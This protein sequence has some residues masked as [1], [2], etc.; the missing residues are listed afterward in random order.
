MANI[1][2]TESNPSWHMN[3]SNSIANTCLSPTSSEM[4]RFSASN[5]DLTLHPLVVSSPSASLL[6]STIVLG[7]NAAVTTPSSRLANPT[8]HGKKSLFLIST[9]LAA[10]PKI[11]APTPA[12]L[13]RKNILVLSSALT[14]SAMMTCKSVTTTVKPPPTQLNTKCS[15]I[16]LIGNVDGNQ[17]TRNGHASSSKTPNTATARMKEWPYRSASAA[18]GIARILGM[19]T[20]SLSM[21]PRKASSC[22]TGAILQS[23]TPGAP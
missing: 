7:I 20:L 11:L 13:A 17:H 14:T 1:S 5:D 22:C 23:W 10:Y 9:P 12:A 4:M 21:P 19:I 6:L 16:N 15:Q 8:A 2:G 3:T 18:N